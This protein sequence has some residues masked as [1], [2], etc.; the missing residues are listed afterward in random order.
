M[1]H[2]LSPWLGRFASDS[3]KG[4][5]SSTA[6]DVEFV[7]ETTKE[8]YFNPVRGTVAGV[9]CAKLK[10]Q[11]EQ[12][13]FSTA[14]GV[15]GVPCKT[16]AVPPDGNCF[17]R[18][19]SQVVCGTDAHHGAIRQAV[20]EQVEGTAVPYLS[21]LRLGYSSVSSYIRD[22]N[23]ASLGIWASEV[24][25]QATAD[26]F[27]VDIYTYYRDVWLAY[28]CTGSKVSDQSIY[29]HNSG[30]HYDAV[31]CAKV[32]D[33]RSCYGYCKS[34]PGGVVGVGAH[35]DRS[36]PSNPSTCESSWPV[37]LSD[38][39]MCADGEGD[40]DGDGDD[41]DADDDD[42]DADYGYCPG[43]ND[44]RYS[45]D[46][47][48]DRDGDGD[49]DMYDD[50]D[51]G[52]MDQAFDHRDEC[53]HDNVNAEA[54]DDGAWYS[55]EHEEGTAGD[56]YLDGCDPENGIAEAEEAED[57]TWA[58][59]RSEPQ[60]KLLFWSVLHRSWHSFLDWLGE[61]WWGS[62]AE[63]EI[64]S[65]MTRPES[66][67]GEIVIAAYS[68]HI[69]GGVCSVTVKT[70]TALRRFSV[71]IRRGH[72]TCNRMVQGAYSNPI[73]VIQALTRDMGYVH[74]LPRP[75]C[76]HHNLNYF[77]VT[78]VMEEMCFMIQ[79][80]K[81]AWWGASCGNCEGSPQHSE[82]IE[83]L[84]MRGESIFNPAAVLH[85]MDEDCSGYLFEIV[86]AKGNRY[87]VTFD[88]LGFTLGTSKR[89]S[90]IT[91]VL[92]YVTKIENVVFVY[93]P[94][95]QMHDRGVGVDSK[96]QFAAW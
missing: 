83:H 43:D 95:S 24:E 82:L 27:G 47:H 50:D 84:R 28:T 87:K 23:M 45:D 79:L 4:S 90:E 48:E 33:M 71:L 70:G 69:P 57:G 30:H 93:G 61:R 44:D 54:R 11:C 10:V 68:G 41:V 65:F 75:K 37:P 21:I 58:A 85:Y 92:A 12:Q 6:S 7:S 36:T 26:F 76:I 53:D 19:V 18:A 34:A 91:S 5:A 1:A 17:F 64:A 25:I 13:T 66:R 73:D 20:V 49:G 3:R 72:Y 56:K 52:T 22:S 15:L 62:V 78:H 29:L 55:D 32:P 89:F 80:L 60:R 38:Y 86:T 59:E 51:D 77:S 14:T 88:T 9:L 35:T 46:E 96:L 39:G 8:L 67:A 81:R 74:V 16:V 63:E 94:R 42:V 31:V 2:A 40:G